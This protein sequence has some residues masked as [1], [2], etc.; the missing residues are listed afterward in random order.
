MEIL[1]DKTIGMSHIPEEDEESRS[2]IDKLFSSFAIHEGDETHPLAQNREYQEMLIKFI[3]P[4]N[5]LFDSV[6]TRLTVA[7]FAWNLS[8]AQEENQEEYMTTFVD[9]LMPESDE[10]E[11]S[12][13]ELIISL[14]DRRDAL[15]P[16]ETSMILPV[17]SGEDLQ[18]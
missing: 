10:G 8:V 12:L 7:V 16:D 18:E 6:T 3:E 11:T 9:T 2:E 4:L 5:G 17:E 1:E 13:R 15:F 14:V